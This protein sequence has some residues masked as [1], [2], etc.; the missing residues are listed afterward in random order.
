MQKEAQLQRIKISS[1]PILR[2]RQ[3]VHFLKRQGERL[4]ALIPAGQGDLHHRSGRE[5]QKPGG[6]RHLPS[7]HIVV[8]CHPHRLQKYPVQMIFGIVHALRHCLQPQFSVQMFLDK[9][10]H[11]LH[12]DHRPVS[13][14][15]L[16]F[17]S[18]F[19]SIPEI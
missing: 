8:H 5:D 14:M 10:D 17:L 19:Y 1:R 13:H 3:L 11:P 18:D 7:L 16:L 15:R 6:L 9:I 12:A 4:P 2:R